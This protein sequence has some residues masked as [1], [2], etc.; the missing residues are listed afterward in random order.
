MQA[1]FLFYPLL[2]NYCNGAQN[3]SQDSIGLAAV[4]T[5]IKT[6][7][8]LPETLQS[9]LWMILVL[10]SFT[11]SME[12]ACVSTIQQATTVSS[13]LHSTMTSP[14]RLQMAKLEPQ[15]NADVSNWFMKVPQDCQHKWNSLSHPFLWY[16]KKGPNSQTTDSCLWSNLV[17]REPTSAPTTCLNIG[18]C[19]VCK[20]ASM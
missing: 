20:A 1:L 3:Q 18:N 17:S 16:F 7:S 6:Q 10:F 11:R 8:L 19:S 14:G 5:H 2:F 13:V 15:M 4:Q 9:M 12:G